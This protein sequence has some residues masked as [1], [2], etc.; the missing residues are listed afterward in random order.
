MKK[1][2]RKISPFVPKLNFAPLRI[3]DVLLV[4]EHVVREFANSNDPVFP[5]GIKDMG[6]LESAVS[7]QHT[8]FGDVLKYD[9]LYSAAATL[10]YG[11]CLNHPFHNG[12]KRTALLSGILLLD[13]NNIVLDNVTQDG[14]YG[15]MIGIAAH[16][17]VNRSSRQDV[18]VDGEVNALADWIK[19][20]AR[21]IRRGERNITYGQLYKILSKFGLVLG[22]KKNNYVDILRRK[23]RLIVPDKLQRIA[24][25]PAPGDS[26]IVR[27]DELKQIRQLLELSEIHG[28]DSVAFYDTQ[29]VVDVFIHIHRKALRKLAKT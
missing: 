25:C 16:T 26:K 21:A 2:R 12:N 23:K 22:D 29:T 15:L 19:T 3:K 9:N 5:P 27:L 1:A 6:L 28:V 20:K 14:L 11:L 17:F 8:G 24:R 10:I 18:D 4:H 7:R 13:R